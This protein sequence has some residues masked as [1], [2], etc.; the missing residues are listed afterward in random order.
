MS[1]G[2][3]GK[4]MRRAL[5]SASVMV[6]A[7]GVATTA[8][9][10]TPTTVPATF[11]PATLTAAGG[12]L[13]VAYTMPTGVFRCAFSVA[14]LGPVLPGCVTTAGA[15]SATI[16]LPPN[17]GSSTVTY[18]FTLGGVFSGGTHVGG[19][20]FSTTQTVTVLP[21][22]TH[23]YVA[24]G[25]SISSG[26][27]ITGSGWVNYTGATSKDATA[28]SGCN[29]SAAAYPSLVSSWL[30]ST[31]SLQLPTLSLSDLPCAGATTSNLWTGSP[32]VKDGLSGGGENSFDHG[33]YPQLDDTGELGTARIV[34]LTAGSGDVRYQTILDACLAASL[35][36]TP[37][38]LVLARSVAPA[39]GM[40]PG[41]FFADGTAVCSSKSPAPAVANV[42]KNIQK[43]EPVL[44]ANF[45]KVVAL[46]P[47]AD[48][49]VTGYPNVLPSTLSAANLRNGCGGI[50]GSLLSFLKPLTPALNAVI[51]QAAATA[52][53]NY[54]NPN[55]G[56]NSFTGGAGHTLCASTSWFGGLNLSAKGTDELGSLLPTAVG[57]QNLA[58]SVEASINAVVTA[59]NARQTATTSL[60]SDGYGYCAVIE[61]TTVKCW[62]LGPNGQLGD[63]KF[64]TSGSQGSAAPVTVV[65]TTGVGSLTGVQTVVGN[66]SGFGGG[67]CALLTTG[68]VDCWGYGAEGQLGN[69]VSYSGSAKG[70]AVPVPVVSTSGSGTLSGVS[71]LV[72]DGGGYCAVLSSGGVDCWGEGSAGELGDGRNGSSNIPVPVVST[73]GTGTLS[74]VGSVV[75]DGN[76]SGDGYCAVLQSGGVDCWGLDV[77]GELGAGSTVPTSQE[78]SLIP[79]VV[80][81]TSG[82]GALSGVTSLVSD[83]AGY[84]ATVSSGGVDCWGQGQS[85]QLGN[86]TYSDSS[87]PVPVVDKTG[88]G[89][90]S[91]VTSVASA[92]GEGGYCAVL[93]SGGVDCWGLGNNGQLGN[94]QF[95]AWASQGS[96]IPVAV[97][98]STNFGTLGGV[99]SLVSDGKGF[100]ATLT[101]GGVDCWGSNSAGQLGSGSAGYAAYPQV[102]VSVTNSG[103]LANVVSVTNSAAGYC[104][105]LANG[106]DVC[107][108][109][110]NNGQLGNG[111]F[112]TSGFEGSTVP[113]AV[114]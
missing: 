63:N 27:G 53:V 92:N 38:S 11:S 47:K 77:S 72:S 73:S 67:Y 76:T 65:S 50:A 16:V 31:T 14:P 99:A 114:E 105:Q 22:A 104:A 7:A 15:Q 51:A 46:A 79:V 1:G 103:P 56:A 8:G 78:G 111:S 57:Q 18:T 48:I 62:G 93:V 64:F 60:A 44:V 86:G 24:L 68:S 81:S 43:L 28:L 71:S 25:D 19:S 97:V 100:C 59:E 55:A 94:G 98:G 13:N 12:I 58:A 75:S 106:N 2:L 80:T 66:Q 26:D 91:N 42:L 10:T 4:V 29:R 113:V 54:V 5:A 90:L 35:G 30:N 82:T 34:T 52:G 37:A 6:A 83:G 17:T 74:G 49:F 87:V 21:S 95:Y 107:W 3:F 70:S 85:G 41:T 20:S 9:A 69:G 96:A 33:E 108:G 40:S 32:A 88:V 39:L 110:G 61:T 23:T 89:T 109:L 101:S 84:C 45:Q 112:Y 102:V 36:E